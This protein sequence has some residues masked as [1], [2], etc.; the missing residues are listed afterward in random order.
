MSYGIGMW[1]TVKTS[2]IFTLLL[3]AQTAMAQLAPNKYWVLFTDKDNSP[4]SLDAPE[5]FLSQRSIDR[6][7][8]QGIPFKQNDLPVNPQYVQQVLD[9]GEIG[10]LYT[11][12]WFNAAG[13]TFTDSTLVEPIEALPFVWEVRQMPAYRHREVPRVEQPVQ[14][15]SDADWQMYGD[16]FHQLWML[17]GHELHEDGFTGEDKLIAV[18]DAGFNQAH[19]IDAFQ[20][21]IQDGRLVGTY[22]FVDTQTNVF[23]SHSH[24]TRV[25]SAMASY[26]PDSLIGA[27]PQASYLLYRTENADWEFQMEEI[28]WVAG[29]EAADSAGA[30]VLNTSLGYTLFEDS[31]QNYTWADLDGQTSWIS[32][33]AN[34][35]A[36]KGM[37]VINSAGNYGAGAWYHIG[38][39]ADADSV[40]AVGALWADSTVSWFSSRG[41]TADGRVKPNVMAQGVQ[42]R[43]ANVN[44]TMMTGN[45]TS[46]SGPIIAGL[47]AC[48]W[49]TQPMATSMQVFRA[50]EESAHL[51]N[52][53]N[54]SLG[55]GIPNFFLAR[56]I[57]N[58]VVLGG[59]DS[60]MSGWIIN[61]FPNPF[62]DEVNLLV[63]APAP[64]NMAIRVYDL[65]GR[66]VHSRE[67]SVGE[68][69]TLVQLSDGWRGLSA[70]MYVLQ[71]SMNNERQSVRIQ[72]VN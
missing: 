60:I 54:D 43:L 8:A 22:D 48:L 62:Y 28:N 31:T 36:S 46:F 39:P 15:R 64:G 27:A 32:R 59:M 26:W 6:R 72:K 51:Y 71:A 3:L 21:L 34:I 66:L 2:T 24:G 58:D 50:I 55:F 18:L 44:N 41:P 68:G 35:A 38:M 65:S 13:F 23:H 63:S 16:G 12:R 37:L 57:L 29:A 42:T 19:E 70:G 67:T 5:A 10:L 69:R 4:Y 7:L 56:M 14:A 49:Q 40:L 11:S 17:N 45:G 30:D 47:A 9:L 52:T 61:S 33:G 25:W 20:P 53:P 1:T